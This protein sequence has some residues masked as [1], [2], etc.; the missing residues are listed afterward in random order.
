MAN[1]AVERVAIIYSGDHAEP[2]VYDD[3]FCAQVREQ[4]LRVDAVLVWVNPLDGHSNGDG[5][6][7]RAVLDVMWRPLAFL[8]TRTRISS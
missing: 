2:A 3:S 1:D 5:D 4:L 7:Q 6:G 8:S